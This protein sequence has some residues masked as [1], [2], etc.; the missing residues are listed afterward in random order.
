MLPLMRSEERLSFPCAACGRRATKNVS[1]LE[2]WWTGGDGK[3]YCSDNCLRLSPR[4]RGRAGSI[5]VRVLA[6]H[7]STIADVVRW[8]RELTKAFAELAIEA[9]VAERERLRTVPSVADAGVARDEQLVRSRTD[10]AAQQMRMLQ[11][12]DGIG[13]RRARRLLE[14]F[15]TPAAVVNASM[16]APTEAVGPVAAERMSTVVRTRAESDKTLV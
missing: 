11:A 8:R 3:P 10:L 4:R 13:P 5:P 6:P 12:I 16:K 14:Y 15:G 7:G 9:C 2:D 1:L